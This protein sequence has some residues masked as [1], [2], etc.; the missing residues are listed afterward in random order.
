MKIVAS[1]IMVFEGK[2]Y[3]IEHD[4]GSDYPK[5][6]ARFMFEEGNY[7]CDCNRKVFLSERYPELGIDKNITKCGNLIEI[8]NL[9]I[10]RED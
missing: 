8:K 7:S 1:M 10:R 9:K 6:S 3:P 4:F 5:E 2:E